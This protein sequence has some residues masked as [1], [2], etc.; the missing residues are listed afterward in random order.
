MDS[1]HGNLFPCSLWPCSHAVSGQLCTYKDV[2]EM[3]F[4]NTTSEPLANTQEVGVVVTL[5]L[6]FLALPTW[7][8]MPREH[9]WKALRGTV[10]DSSFWR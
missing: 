3:L 9:F 4:P 2:Q 6:G 5:D 1:N 10:D 7:V 8:S